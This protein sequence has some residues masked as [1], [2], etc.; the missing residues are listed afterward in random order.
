[1]G[2]S[3]RCLD[4]P[5]Q[6][7]KDVPVVIEKCHYLPSNVSLSPEKRFSFFVVY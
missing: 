4:L 6:C 1:M 5:L 3:F 2:E 7:Y